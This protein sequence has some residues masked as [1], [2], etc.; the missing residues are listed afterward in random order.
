MGTHKDD[1]VDV[2][3]DGNVETWTVKGIKRWVD[4]H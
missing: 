4:L 1:H 3:I 2:E